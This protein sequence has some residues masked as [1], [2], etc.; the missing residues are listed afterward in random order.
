MTQRNLYMDDDELKLYVDVQPLFIDE[1]ENSKNEAAASALKAAQ[2]EAAAKNWKN[3]I[4]DY[5]TGIELFYAQASDDI[6]NLYNNS[7]S[8]LTLAKNSAINDLQSQKNTIQS[9]IRNSLNIAINNINTTAQNYV[10]QAQD[11]A[12]QAQITVDNRVST[13]HLNQSK[14]LET[15]VIS[16]DEEVLRDVKL[17]A[18][19]TYVGHQTE[20]S[21]PGYLPDGVT[22]LDPKK[23]IKVGSG[24]TVTTAGIA[25]G[26]SNSNYLTTY[27]LK[28]TYDTFEVQIPFKWTS[29][30]GVFLSDW[31]NATYRGIGLITN[32]SKILLFLSSNGSSWDIANTLSG[33][34]T[35]SADT[36]YILTLSFDGTKYEVKLKNLVSG[37]ETT[38]ITV[39]SSNKIYNTNAKLLLGSLGRGGTWNVLNGSID[40]K[41]F[42]ITVDGVPVFSG[43]R[44]G[45]DTIKPVNFTVNTTMYAW[46]YDTHTIYANGFNATT[47]APTELY[48]KTGRLITQS[49]STWQI[50]VDSD[51]T[52]V[53]YNGNNA[54]YTSGSNITTATANSPLVNPQLPIEAGAKITSDG[55]ASGF[56]IRSSNGIDTGFYIPTDKDFEIEMEFVLSGSDVTGI[57]QTHY[58]LGVQHNASVDKIPVSMYFN[59][60]QSGSAVVW[61]VDVV[62]SNDTITTLTMSVTV[63][64]RS[65][66]DKIKTTLR[67]DNATGKYIATAIVNG[68]EKTPVSVDSTLDL[69]WSPRIYI[70][71]QKT[72]YTVLKFFGSIDL[73]SFKIYV[74][75]DLVYQPCLKIPFTES[76][77]GSK[78]VNSIYRPRVNDMYEQ[79][80]YAPYYTLSDTDFSLPKGE[81]YGMIEKLRELIMQQTA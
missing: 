31:S 38:E 32:N 62:D 60:G 72:N 5:K 24:I 28:N 45:I 54:T 63:G 15:G 71:I 14:G 11:Y 21:T 64:Q 8:D 34:T 40:L 23:F 65:A 29:G 16:I 80:G 44:T 9:D 39:T 26:F 6:E 1:L 57:G 33:E 50:V 69:V 10:N 18:H 22:P 46:V 30:Q 55:I 78:I 7:V 77:T 61:K 12:H 4:E 76:K 27:A 37:V 53:K 79:F 13:D 67:R 81:I 70:G 75:D 49:A 74:D 25:S 52:Y 2:S 48:D 73:N 66:G 47:N 36:D 68:E 35:L 51:N 58:I 19:S 42:S 59:A 3:D 41:Q 43:N 56:G 17:Y 20:G